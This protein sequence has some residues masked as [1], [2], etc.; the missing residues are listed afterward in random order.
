MYIKRDI[1]YPLLCKIIHTKG[2]KVMKRIIAIVCLLTMTTLML[3]SCGANFA[4]MEKKL[5]KEGYS[6]T[7]L[8]K[9][10]IEEND[11]DDLST[12]EKVVF[13]VVSGALD[14]LKVNGVLIAVKAEGLFDI[15]SVMVI[16]F[17]EKADADAFAKD[18][19]DVVQKGKVVYMGDEESIKIVK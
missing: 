10:D 16:E 18:N 12:S 17:A 15:K 7:Y 5:E 4:G 9:E 11:T 13:A 3:A 14:D 8:D 1:N 2:E 19:D 6:A